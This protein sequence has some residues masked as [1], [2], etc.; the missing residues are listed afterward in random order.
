MY[1][2]GHGVWRLAR[3][4]AQSVVVG[5]G[6]GTSKARQGR[7]GQGQGKGS[8]AP[9]LHGSSL[10][11][12]ECPCPCPWPAH[13]GIQY[14]PPR[15]LVLVCQPLDLA[16]TSSTRHTRPPSRC[17][18][19]PCAVL[20]GALSCCAVCPPSILA[21]SSL[22]SA[23]RYVGP[24]PALLPSRAIRFWHACCR[25][26]TLSLQLSPLAYLRGRLRGALA[27]S[28]KLSPTASPAS[29]S[30]KALPSRRAGPTRPVHR[31][32]RLSFLSWAWD[33]SKGAQIH[34]TPRPLLQT[35]ASCHPSTANMHDLKPLVLPQLAAVRKSSKGS[36]I[37]AEDPTSSIYS[38]ADSGFYSASE[39]STPPTP[40]QYTR[41]HFRFPSSASSL[42]SSPPTYDLPDAPNG[43][44]KLP[45]LTEDPFERDYDFV[46]EDV[47][48]CSCKFLPLSC[49]ILSLSI[50]T[51]PNLQATHKAPMATPSIAGYPG[52]TILM[53]STS[54]RLATRDYNQQREGG[55]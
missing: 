14:I 20:F 43:S 15:C 10:P 42:S 25:P 35:A 31:H 4:G 32:A 39:C 18:L 48:R 51:Y 24:I 47:Y 22:A 6:E 46:T 21:A 11:L 23:P 38:N 36:L 41:G 29:L 13:T 16:P 7:Q 30:P 52:P 28:P 8:C 17:A 19:L 49:R 53:T 55:R 37:M 50:H 45:K 27:P 9:W 54:P 40:C 44:G 26:L 2:T 3:L 12:S 1:R 5:K 34:L 33:P